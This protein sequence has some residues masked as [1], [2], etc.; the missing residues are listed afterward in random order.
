MDKQM[1][2]IMN[3]CIA[4]SLAVIDK[5]G[6]LHIGLHGG[7]EEILLCVA[8]VL[9]DVSKHNDIPLEEIGKILN[10]SANILQEGD[11][12]HE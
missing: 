4:A 2:K 12:K 11:K 1:D 8:R 3:N 10:T 6:C 5:E 9:I 7:V